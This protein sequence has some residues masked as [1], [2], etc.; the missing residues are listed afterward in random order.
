V[1]CSSTFSTTRYLIL[2]IGSVCAMMFVNLGFRCV[3]SG[4]GSESSDPYDVWP[5]NMLG[6]ILRGKSQ[7]RLRLRALLTREA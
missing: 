6:K 4:C 5:T 3:F 1:T 2:L 7:G